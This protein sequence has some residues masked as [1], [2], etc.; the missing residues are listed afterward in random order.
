MIVHVYFFMCTLLYLYFYI[1]YLTLVVEDLKTW[2]QEEELA[3]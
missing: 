3:L 2:P 1:L